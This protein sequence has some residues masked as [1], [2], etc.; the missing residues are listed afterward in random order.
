MTPGLQAALRRL[1][2]QWRNLFRRIRRRFLV[3][4]RPATHMNRTTVLPRGQHE[5]DVLPRFGLTKFAHRFPRETEYISIDIGG[6]V[7]HSIRV[8][9]ELKQLE[10][11]DQASDFHCVT[12]WTK[13]AVSWSGFRFSDFYQNLIVAQAQP[14]PETAFVVF[15]S[16]DGY[17]VGLLLEDLLAPDVMLAD[18]LEGQPLSIAHGAPLRLVAPAHYGYKS[19]KHINGIEFWRDARNYRPAALSF[20]DH[21]RA[22]VEHEERGKIFP[23]WFLRRLYRPLIKPTKRK[24]HQALVDYLKK[25]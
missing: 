11:I 6:D 4:H 8:S 23:G 24:F 19:A 18:T 25:L 5:I 2:G 21:P 12:T 17:R 3:F 10:R 15:R 20:M 13:R 9:A 16:Q 1:Q 7:K 22:R 14:D